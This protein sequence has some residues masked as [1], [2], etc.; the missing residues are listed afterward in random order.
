MR[1]N[2]LTNDKVCQF[3]RR[4]ESATLVLRMFFW[5]LVRF[6]FRN[7]DIHLVCYTK[8]TALAGY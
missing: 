7:S 5:V 6:A 3:N 8:V 2:L 4:T 1:E